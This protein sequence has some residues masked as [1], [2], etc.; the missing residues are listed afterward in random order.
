MPCRLVASDRETDLDPVAAEEEEPEEQEQEDDLETGYPSL[1]VGPALRAAR[2][3]A[4][5]RQSDLARYLGVD[6]SL[7]SRWEGFDPIHNGMTTRYRPV[8]GKYFAPLTDLLKCSLEELSPDL[9][10]A[11]NGWH[12]LQSV[13]S[14][15][16][17]V[18]TTSVSVTHAATMSGYTL[19]GVVQEKPNRQPGRPP[20]ELVAAG[21]WR[22]H[23]PGCRKTYLESMSQRAPLLCDACGAPVRA[24]SS[25]T[26]TAW[27]GRTV[28]ATVSLA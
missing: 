8:P 6:S 14:T 20:A 2:L 27:L 19:G 15:A 12:S 25:V 24:M 21:Q 18:A 22:R 3:R 7:P 4:G 13:T 26:S 17:A 1:F 28:N 10:V 9:G 16:S 23:C 5:L 11:A